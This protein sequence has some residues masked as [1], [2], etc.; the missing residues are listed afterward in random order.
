MNLANLIISKH[1]ADTQ[2]AERVQRLD[3]NVRTTSSD[4]CIKLINVLLCFQ[5]LNITQDCLSTIST[6]VL[7]N[8]LWQPPDTLTKLWLHQITEESLYLDAIF[9]PFSHNI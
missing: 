8:N 6:T 3:I 4:I 9:V 5:K 7:R 1:L 2:S